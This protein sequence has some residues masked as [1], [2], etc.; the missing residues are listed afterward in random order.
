MVDRSITDQLA[1]WRHVEALVGTTVIASL[2]AMAGSGGATVRWVGQRLVAVVRG[3]SI[4]H[5][6]IPARYI[7][8]ENSGAGPISAIRSL[9]D[10]KN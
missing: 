9:I 3:S 5:R 4:S 8:P 6:S 2:L 1:Q 7:L 10:P